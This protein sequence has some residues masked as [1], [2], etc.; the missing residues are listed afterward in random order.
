[1]AK[2]EKALP[3]SFDITFAFNRF[4]LGGD[5]FFSLLLLGGQAV[6]F[7]GL[8]IVVGYALSRGIQS[9]ELSLCPRISGLSAG[10]DDSD[11]YL[12]LLFWF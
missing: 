3:Q 8:G 11:I 9:G 4:V 1:M 10:A 7:R 6:P 5:R 12:G 2:I